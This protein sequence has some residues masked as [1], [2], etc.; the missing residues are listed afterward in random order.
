MEEQT[1]PQDP[2]PKTSTGVINYYAIPVS[3][4]IAG[5]AIASA[6]FIYFGGSVDPTQNP[7]NQKLTLD[8][9]TK[10]DHIMG[11]LKAKVIIVEYSDT[12]CPFC[13]VFHGTMNRISNE[14]D[15]NQV[16]WVYR[17]YPLPFHTKAPKE[18]EAT[19]CAA[20]L[21]GNEKFWQYTNKIFEITPGNDGLDAALLPKIA[22]ELGLD[23]KA[24]E[25]CLASG[26]MKPIV[27]KDLASGGKAGVGGTPH[28]LIVVNG[29]V[30]DVINGAQPY[31]VVKSQIDKALKLK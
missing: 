21:G 6:F 29:K 8:P 9:V 18:A 19:E 15:G 11:S 17:H 14:Y 22:L 13:K 26:E 7:Q 4:F 25:K 20:K 2:T 30:V 10:S 16:A 24:F 12:E 1:T 23:Q 3:M 5:F 31:D 28:S 27:D